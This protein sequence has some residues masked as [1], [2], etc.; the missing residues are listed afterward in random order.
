MRS[1][2]FSIFAVLAGGLV[3]DN[4]FAATAPNYCGA[5]INGCQQSICTAASGNCDVAPRPQYDA[6]QA[7]ASTYTPCDNTTGTKCPSPTVSRTACTT[8][9]YTKNISGNCATQVCQ[10]VTSANGC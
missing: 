2:L 5:A 10:T 1:V 6:S 8:T 9:Y 7:T 4:A 3:I